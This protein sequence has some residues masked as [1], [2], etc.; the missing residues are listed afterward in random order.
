MA[1][2]SDRR[3][4]E[5]KKSLRKMDPPCHFVAVSSDNFFLKR[6]LKIND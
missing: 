5:Q 4:K 1:N 3:D 2:T 6:I